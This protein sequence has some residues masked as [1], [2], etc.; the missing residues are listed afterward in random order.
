MKGRIEDGDLT[1]RVRQQSIHGGDGGEFQTVVRGRKL[2]VRGDGVSNF[3]S[4]P[5]SLAILGSR[6]YYAMRHR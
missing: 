2:S 3:R 4:K 6:V 5:C 1:C